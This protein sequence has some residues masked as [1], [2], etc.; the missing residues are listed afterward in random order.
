MY[1]DRGRSDEHWRIQ[2]ILEYL[3]LNNNHSAEELL[4]SI[5]SSTDI[6]TWNSKR[7]KLCTK[8]TAGLSFFL[9][10]LA[11]LEIDKSL[12]ANGWVL[13]RLAHEDHVPMRISMIWRL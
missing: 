9:K 1:I 3:N 6:V 11:E 5:L 13:N 10:G 7:E 4:Q 2:D 8:V 12:I